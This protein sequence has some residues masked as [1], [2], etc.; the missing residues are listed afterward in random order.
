MCGVKVWNVVHEKTTVT[1][2]I[3]TYIPLNIS[4]NILNISNIT[5]CISRLE[6]LYV[7]AGEYNDT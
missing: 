5:F 6:W 3:K 1:Y 4:D 2:E 7:T